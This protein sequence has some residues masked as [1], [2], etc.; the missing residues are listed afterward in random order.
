MAKR[1]RTLYVEVIPEFSSWSGAVSGFRFGTVRKRP[2]RGAEGP[3][4][5]SL[6]VILDDSWLDPRVTVEVELPPQ[7]EAEGRVDVP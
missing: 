3:L 2:R 4:E 5:V 7:V 1:Q 6:T